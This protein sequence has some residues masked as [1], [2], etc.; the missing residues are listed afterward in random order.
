MTK[1]T[2]RTYARRYLDAVK[3][4]RGDLTFAE[5]AKALDQTP[6]NFHNKRRD[7]TMPVWQL[8]LIGEYLGADV[9]LVD[10]KTGKVIV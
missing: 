5:L 2:A 6:Q 9:K 3:K 10:R 7:G 1:K 4:V 8:V